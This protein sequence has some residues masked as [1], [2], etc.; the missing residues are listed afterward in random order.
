MNIFGAWLATTVGSVVADWYT[1]VK[2]FKR[3]DDA[4]LELNRRGV[5]ISVAVTASRY[6]STVYQIVQHF[7]ELNI[8]V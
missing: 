2:A 5:S 6:L 7:Y 1:G 4:I 8:G 3:V